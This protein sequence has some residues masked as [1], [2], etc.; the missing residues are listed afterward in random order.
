MYLCITLFCTGTSCLVTD[1][2]VLCGTRKGTNRTQKAREG[3]RMFVGNDREAAAGVPVVW[4]VLEVRDFN[5][6]LI[7][8]L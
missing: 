4:I 8:T 5:F 3:Y 6:I 1:N 2:V 7:K